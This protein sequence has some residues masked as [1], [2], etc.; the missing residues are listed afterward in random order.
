M[1][2]PDRE[3]RRAGRARLHGAAL[4]VVV[5]AAC[6]GDGMMPEP[7]DQADPATSVTAT[8]TSSGV[9]LANPGSE[10]LAYA[11][12]EREFST[13]SLFSPCIDPG[14]ACV[15]LPAGQSVVVPFAQI[16]GYTSGARE[17][18]A[19]TWRVVRDSTGSY[20]A[21]DFKSQVLRL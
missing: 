20:R 13:R 1:P 19:Y 21:A 3:T 7:D 5:A 14:P 8:A 11:V 4:A 15:R 10:P 18:V 2:S 6:S 17:V 9:R 12:F 16:T